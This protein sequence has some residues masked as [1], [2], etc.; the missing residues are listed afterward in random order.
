MRV[1]TYTGPPTPCASAKPSVP[2]QNTLRL[3]RPMAQ[4]PLR[5]AATCTKRSEVCAFTGVYMHR[6]CWFDVHGTEPYWSMKEQ[7]RDQQHLA[8]APDYAA[9]EVPRNSPT[10]FVTAFFATVIGFA[11]IWYIWWM[12]IAGLVGAYATFVVFAWR[13]RVD[14]EIPAATV[15]EI[16]GRNRRARGQALA[17]MERSA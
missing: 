1:G 14:Y 6:I 5:A 15:A 4:V 7:A 13:D 9:I 2:Q 12:A 10:G 8:A 11:M 17:A 16:D 3:V